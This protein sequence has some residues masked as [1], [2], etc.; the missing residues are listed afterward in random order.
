MESKEILK[1]FGKGLGIFGMIAAFVLP[2]SLVMNKFIYHPPIVRIILGILGGIGSIVTLL[3]LKFVE[4]K[5]GMIET[6]ETKAYYFG[7]FPLL[8]SPPTV[9]EGWSAIFYRFIINPALSMFRANIYGSE[10]ADGLRNAVV[11]GYSLLPEPKPEDIQQTILLGKNVTYTK[12]GVSEEAIRAA[13]KAGQ[14]Q[15][16]LW[17]KVLDAIVDSK[18][19]EVQSGASLATEIGLTN[20]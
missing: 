10:D 12:G 4:W 20:V 16:A 9:P 18:I 2:M 1:S 15:P 13:Q 6:G 19:F 7:L 3:V 8:S 5:Q 14:V 17:G 11:N